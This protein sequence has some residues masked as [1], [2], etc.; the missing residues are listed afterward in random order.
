MLQMM[1][2]DLEDCLHQL[3]RVV[4]EDGWKWK[5]FHLTQAWYALECILYG[6]GART[7]KQCESVWFEDEEI[8]RCEL[9]V[10]HR[11]KHQRT[12]VWEE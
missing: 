1:K 10:G 7:K 8:F 12:L 6:H 9:K 11:G 3:V 2:E 4:H 5:K